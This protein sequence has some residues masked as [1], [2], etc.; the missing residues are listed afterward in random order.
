MKYDRDEWH[1]NGDFPDDVPPENGGT[2][3]GMFLAWAILHGLAGPDHH[4]HSKTELDAVQARLMT[5]REFLR[6]RC[7]GKFWSCDLNDEGN[8]F[9]KEY[10]GGGG[11][12]GEYFDDY[13][14]VLG[15]YH[16][17]VYHVEDT[18]ENYDLIAEEI[19]Y[20]YEQ[21]REKHAR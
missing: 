10:Y 9:A 18:W 19:D 12:A 21:W 3:I 20:A 1:S 17:S 16:E 2:H 7:S 13:F 5:G 4:R 15:A 11:K 6:R 8:A 14:D